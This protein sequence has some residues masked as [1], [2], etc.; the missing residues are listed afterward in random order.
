TCRGAGKR[1]IELAVPRFFVAGVFGGGGGDVDL[2]YSRVDEP[3]AAE[4]LVWAVLEDLEKEDV[5]RDVAVVEVFDDALGGVVERGGDDDDLVRVVEGFLVELCSETGFEIVAE[6]PAVGE[7]LVDLGDLV[8]G[9]GVHPRG[10]V[11]GLGDDLAR[12]AVALE[13]DEHEGAVGRDGEEIDAAGEGRDFLPTDEHPLAG[14]DARIADDHV[15][16]RLLG[17]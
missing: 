9:E 15:L 3:G 14:K 16:Q 17:S 1:Y 12:G 2:G 8:G 4:E 6:V 10:V 5:D 13:L 7:A 11:E